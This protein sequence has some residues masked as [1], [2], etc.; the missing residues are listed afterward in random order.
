[1]SQEIRMRVSYAETMC[2]PTHYVPPAMAAK[3]AGHTSFT[4]PDGLCC[5]KMQDSKYP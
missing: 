5:P 1:M 3:R 2:N 4:L